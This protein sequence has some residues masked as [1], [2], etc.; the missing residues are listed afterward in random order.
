MIKS[1]IRYNKAKPTHVLIQIK[2]LEKAK[3]SGHFVQAASMLHPV[4][5]LD[6]NEVTFY[7]LKVP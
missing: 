6:E 7:E 1:Q 5:N 2:A 4:H 3:S